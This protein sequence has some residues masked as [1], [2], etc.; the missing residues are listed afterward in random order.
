MQLRESHKWH[1]FEIRDVGAVALGDQR[2]HV[3]PFVVP[4]ADWCV[5][6][7]AG[8]HAE[9]W[10]RRRA[11]ESLIGKNFIRRRM[12][13]GHQPHLIEIHGFFHRLHEPETEQAVPSLHAARRHLQVLIGI[14]NVPLPGRD[15]VADHAW[16]DHVRNE[17]ILAP[18]PGKQ[19]GA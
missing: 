17:F 13:D 18:I 19:N 5:R 11:Y 14:G 6:V 15:P 7:A 9:L 12:I 1:L 10:K 8:D 16:T 3:I 4:R 2:Q